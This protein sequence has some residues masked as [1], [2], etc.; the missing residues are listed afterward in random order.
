MSRSLSSLVPSKSRLTVRKDQEGVC[1][2]RLHIRKEKKRN[3]NPQPFFLVHTEIKPFF[4][5]H[6]VV[7]LVPVLSGSIPSSASLCVSFGSA[8]CL[9]RLSVVCRKGNAA[10][11]S[12]PVLFLPKT[13][14][15]NKPVRKKLFLC[16]QYCLK[17]ISCSI[18]K[19][20]QSWDLL[21]V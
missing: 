20:C 13:K 8:L 12:F 6:F 9:Q 5:F 2:Q 3:H 7:Y 19:L 21:S 11:I 18:F 17:P 1:D 16:K 4:S 10:M 14:Q 15:K